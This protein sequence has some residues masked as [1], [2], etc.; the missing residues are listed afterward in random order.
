MGKRGRGGRGVARK[1]TSSRTRVGRKT[2]R[3][4]GMT[5]RGSQLK[6]GRVGSRMGRMSEANLE[7]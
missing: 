5:K 3:T 6:R 4:S 1:A 2:R 7:E